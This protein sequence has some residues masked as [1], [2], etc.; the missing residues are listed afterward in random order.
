MLDI[1][2]ASTDASW[3]ILARFFLASVAAERGHGR[4]P[5]TAKR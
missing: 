4:S 1:G 2:Q 5:A 3:G